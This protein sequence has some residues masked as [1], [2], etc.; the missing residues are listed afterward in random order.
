LLAGIRSIHWL[1]AE[2]LVIPAQMHCLQL[3]GLLALVVWVGLTALLAETVAMV[4][5]RQPVE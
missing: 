3:A 1:Q 4:G 5:T 2:V